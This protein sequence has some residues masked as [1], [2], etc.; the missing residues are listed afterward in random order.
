MLKLLS[1]LLLLTVTATH[2][3]AGNYFYRFSVEG[4][5]VI[6]D[7][8]PA[9]LAPLGYEV[10]DSRGMVIRTVARELTAS[11][12]AERERRIAAAKALEARK[13]ARRKQDMDIL[14]QYASAA[15]ITRSLKR[16]VDDM[17]S[18]IAQQMLLQ[19]DLRNKLEQQ[20]GRAAGHERNG[21][22]VPDSLRVDIERL[23]AGLADIDAGIA[24]RE[25]SI[26]ALEQ[27]YE[28]LYFRFR[29]LHVY[30][31]GT[32]EEEVDPQR[33]PE[34]VRDDSPS[35]VKGLPSPAE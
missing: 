15:D 19:Q 16:K 33:L 14:R 32:L 21:R 20:Q 29:V 5:T 13:E 18:Q 9:E 11:E 4:R 8:V 31:P 12:I 24:R 6:K 28:Q 2:A 17:R 26:T 27:D 23:Q 22:D 25:A 35:A 10:L 30:E 34:D 7:Y 3:L 1:G